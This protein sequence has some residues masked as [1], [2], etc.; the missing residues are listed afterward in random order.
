MLNFAKDGGRNMTWVSRWKNISGRILQLQ[1]VSKAYFDSINSFGVDHYG[2]GGSS[3]I[4]AAKDLSL[5]IIE[6][7]R[8]FTKL[9]PK[10]VGLIS[11]LEKNFSGHK[12]TGIPGVGGAMVILGVFNS[13]MNYYLKD[14]EILVKE[15]VRRSF[16]HLQRSL[17]ADPEL[18]RK[19]MV[20]FQESDHYVQKL[21]GLHLLMHGIWGFKVEENS[22]RG[23]LISA[24][25]IKLEEVES[26]GSS[27]VMT[28]W[29]RVNPEN[30]AE[31]ARQ[32]YAKAASYVGRD[33]PGTELRTERYLV[34]VSERPLAMPRNATDGE[35]EYVYVNVA[36]NP[37]L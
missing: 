9:P 37:V 31:K 13:E 32:A 15:N 28:E 29:A 11:K 7:K 30:A 17:M 23:D 6:L 20:G 21:G 25:P 5:E 3:I 12:F 1:E 19:W 22:E 18:Q 2:I 36:L 27:L 33:L 16:H 8:S 10:V 26:S 34:L 4:P 14:Q 24:G 35:V